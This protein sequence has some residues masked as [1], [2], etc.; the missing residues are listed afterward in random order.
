MVVCVPAFFFFFS[1][2]SQS[3][4]RTRRDSNTGCFWWRAVKYFV[5]PLHSPF[6]TAVRSSYFS[7]Y[8]T[9]T[10]CSTLSVLCRVLGRCFLPTMSLRLFSAFY[11]HD[12]E[13]IRLGGPPCRRERV[14]RIHGASKL[15]VSI[16]ISII[17]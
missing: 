10:A 15:Q 1:H 9:N 16:S 2:R 14:P 6:V 7:T 17:Q 13:R 5:S 4:S 11:D 3:Y 12:T 8:T